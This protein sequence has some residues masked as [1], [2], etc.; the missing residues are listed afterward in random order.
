MMGQQKYGIQRKDNYNIQYNVIL[1][2]LNL[3]D[4]VII[5]L[6]VEVIKLSIFGRLGFMI[7][8]TKNPW[9][10]SISNLTL[11]K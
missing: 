7:V 11:K 4:M 2:I 5:L 8:L 6:Q 10:S 9:R 3:V 1:I